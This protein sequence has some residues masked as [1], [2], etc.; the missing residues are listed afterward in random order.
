MFVLSLS[1]HYITLHNKSST[2]FALFSRW[3]IVKLGGVEGFSQIT[4][5]GLSVFTKAVATLGLPLCVCCE[6]AILYQSTHSFLPY[7]S[8]L[9]YSLFF[10]TPRL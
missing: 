4:E 9:V 10:Y 5:L 8:Y 7:I 1:R 6:K 2:I 3:R